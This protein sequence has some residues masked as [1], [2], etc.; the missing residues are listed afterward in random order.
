LSILL[1]IF[2]SSE[3]TNRFFFLYAAQKVILTNFKQMQMQ[4]PRSTNMLQLDKDVENLH[5]DLAAL[6]AHA[7][8]LVRNNG[9][10]LFVFFHLTRFAFLGV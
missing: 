9:A 4:E 1:C 7:R 5:L 2:V 3:R 6:K 10:S 8:D